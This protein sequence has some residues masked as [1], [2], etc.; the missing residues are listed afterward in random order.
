VVEK[1]GKKACFGFISETINLQGMSNYIFFGV[2][3]KT[4]ILVAVSGLHLE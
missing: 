2:G 1:K 4:K 3:K